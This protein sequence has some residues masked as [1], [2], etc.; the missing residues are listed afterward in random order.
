MA[1]KQMLIID[2]EAENLNLLRRTFIREYSVYSADNAKDALTILNEKPGISLIISDQRMAEMTGTE[3]FKIVAKDRPDIMKILLTAYTDMEAL[4][5]A[6]NDGQIYKYITKPWDPEELKLTIKRAYEVYDLAEENKRLISD[7]AIKNA[8]LQK[9]KDYTD[10]RI[11]EER[12]RISRE[13]HDDICQS[14]A[15]LNINMEI[16]MRL[17]KSDLAED[18]INT[19]KDNLINTREQIKDTSKRV[20]RI[21]M[22]LRPAELDSLGFVSTLEQFINRYN[23]TPDS[24]KVELKIIGDIITLPQKLELGM[25]RIIQ[26]CL[27]NAKK[28]AKATKIDVT[29][30]FDSDKLNITIIDDGIGFEIP[31]HLGSLLQKGHLGI[32]GMY[33][34]LNQLGGKLIITSKPEEG[35]IINVTIQ[36]LGGTFE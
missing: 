4:V 3:F 8:E 30:A 16:C 10:E 14:L 6:I 19:I 7:L 12:L 33:E 22:D 18:K 5:E 9:M 29:L 34:R 26:E 2:D 1:K 21:S 25:F 36:T 32:V 11:E 13:L 27:N 20:R 35:T 17:L 28:H 15:S 31:E 24:A 23:S